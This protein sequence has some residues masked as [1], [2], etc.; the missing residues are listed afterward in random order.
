MRSR[1]SAF[2]LAQ[3]NYVNETQEDELEESYGQDESVEWTK[4]EIHECRKGR[5]DDKQGW[6]WFTATY[7]RAGQECEMNEHSYFIRKSGRWMYSGEESSVSY[8]DEPLPQKRKR[9]EP[10]YCGSGKKFKRCCMNKID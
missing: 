3:F 8:I 1:Y 10:C 4:L 2:A 9:N 6:V 5:P 7:V